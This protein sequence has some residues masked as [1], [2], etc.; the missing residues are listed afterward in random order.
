MNWVKS[1]IFAVNVHVFFKPLWLIYG[2]KG[3]LMKNSSQL[4][5][6]VHCYYADF[7]LN[8]FQFKNFFLKEN[9]KAFLKYVNYV[10]IYH[11]GI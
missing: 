8:C 10:I 3:I 1:S 9:Y 7:H 4:D 11:L 2:R 5:K 6:P